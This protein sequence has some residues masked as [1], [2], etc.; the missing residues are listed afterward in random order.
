M[1][2]ETAAFVYTYNNYRNSA[3]NGLTMAALVSTLPSI[4]LLGRTQL[5]LSFTATL[6]GLCLFGETGRAASNWRVDGATRPG[7]T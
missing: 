7:T 1:G 3:P 6:C 2:G 5:E 4:C